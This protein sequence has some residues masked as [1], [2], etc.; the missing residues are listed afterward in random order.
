MIPEIMIA[1]FINKLGSSDL[2]SFIKVLEAYLDTDAFI[3]PIEDVGYNNESGYVY[4]FLFN[5]IQIACKFGENVEFIINDEDREE[6][7]FDNYN[8]ALNRV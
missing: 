8:D 5:G 3:N 2:R 1:N 4:L 6:I 7:F